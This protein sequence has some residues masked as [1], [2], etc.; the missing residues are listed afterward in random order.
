VVDPDGL[1][2]TGIRTGDLLFDVAVDLSPGSPGFGKVYAVWQDARFSGLARDEIAFA[3]STDGGDTW[4]API[5]LNQTPTNVPSGNRQAFTPSVHVSA[6]GT[7]GVTYYDFRNNTPDPT[8]LP[9]D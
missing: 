3:M 4:S 1:A 5:K 9:T 8:T 2:P 7:V 6:D